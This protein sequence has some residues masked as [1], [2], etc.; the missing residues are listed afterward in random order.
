MTDILLIDLDETILDFHA[1]EAKA[2]RRT[3]AQMDVPPTDENAALYSRLNDEEWKRYERGETTRERLVVHRFERL[4]AILG[5][6]RDALATKQIY[7]RMLAEGHDL[8]PGAREALE[9]LSHRFALYLVSNGTAKVQD[10]RLALAD[11]NRYFKGIF[12]SE[13]VGYNKPKKEFFDV[14]FATL[15]EDARERAI[16]LGDSLTSDILG[17]INAGIGTVWINTRALPPREDIVPDS[18]F[19]SLAAFVT[20]L[21]SNEK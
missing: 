9:Y 15:G 3:L 1:S 17:G 18:S 20:Y 21:K 14:V 12:V 11:L 8:L 5:I 10:S 16:I 6:E 13:R 2:I 4:Y 19:P 7:E